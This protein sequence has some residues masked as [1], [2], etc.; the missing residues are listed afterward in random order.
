MTGDCAGDNTSSQSCAASVLEQGAEI[1]YIACRDTF[2]NQDTAESN[3]HLSYFVDTAPPEQSAW[4]PAKNATV[5]GT[6]VTITLTTSENADC[7]WS[8]S[9]KDYDEMAGDC[10]GG[11]A[12]SQ[13]CAVSGLAQGAATVYI[14]CRDMNSNA[15]TAETN[16]HLN[17]TVRMFYPL[18]TITLAQGWNL[19]GVS[20]QGVTL[21]PASVFGG[22][23]HEIIEFA[24]GKFNTLTEQQTQQLGFASGY[25]IYSENALGEI[26]VGGSAYTGTNYTINLSSGW[27]IFSNPFIQAI[28]WHAS[29]A[30][31]TCNG[32]SAQLPAIYYYDA[33]AGNYAKINPGNT[34]YISPWLGYLI[35]INNNCTLTLNK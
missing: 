14:A 27:N 5:T 3:Q 11:G 19:A 12:T 35:Y 1:V 25:W 9:D 7:K 32:A 34:S 24:A 29:N 4:K 20:K 16:E 10:A 31:L 8:L 2:G 15:D 28:K 30:S 21:T 22:A 33:A 23:G 18:T 17:Y 6:A 26:A 13:S